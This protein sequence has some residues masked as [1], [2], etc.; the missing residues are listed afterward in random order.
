MNIQ[1]IILLITLSTIIT[2]SSCKDEE[3]VSSAVRVSTLP[4]AVI[5]GY[6]SAEM[7]L[8]SLG[9]EFAPQGTQLLVEV[10]YIDINP[11]ATSGKWQDMVSVGTNGKYVINVPSDA[12][13]VNVRITPFAFE[14]SQIQAYGSLFAQVKKSYTTPPFIIAIR[15]G[16]T[17]SND[18]AYFAADLPNFIDQVRVSGKAQAN[19]NDEIV[20]LE[21]IPNG[22]FLNF[23]NGSWKD[24]VI[25]QNGMYTIDIPKGQLLSYKTEFTCSKRTWIMN[26]DPSLSSYQ[27]I[28]YKFTGTGT[29]TFTT[30]TTSE[31]F[32]ALGV[33]ITIDPNENTVILSGKAEAQLDESVTGLEKMPDG[34]KIYFYTAGWGA[35]ATVLN[36]LY[37][38]I[39]PKNQV[40]NYTILF[41]TNKKISS[42]VSYLSI[43]YLYNLT[44]TTTK[45]SKTATLDLNAG[46]GTLAP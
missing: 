45:A 3:V 40:V 4:N 9:T 33:D 2:Y 37:N 29:K 32:V 36:G 24:S 22:T 20:G 44:N 17:L 19:I 1:K 28:N 11:T 16:Q 42:G 8:Q 31:D 43:P 14:A 27:N 41:S 35:T 21:N 18:F 6:V 10:N 26:A 30:S 23:Y 46:T 12:N 7:N 25:I 38:I 15:S 5:T 13:G 39:I 34:T